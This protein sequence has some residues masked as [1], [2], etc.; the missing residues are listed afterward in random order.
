MTAEVSQKVSEPVSVT[1]GPCACVHHDS[2]ECARIRDRSPI[3]D[4]DDYHRRQ[5]ECDCHE[6]TS[7]YG[8]DY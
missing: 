7:F 3:A 8:D 1:G 5:C 6:R 2:Y 4:F